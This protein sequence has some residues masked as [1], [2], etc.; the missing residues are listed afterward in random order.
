MDIQHYKN[1]RQLVFSYHGITFLSILALLIG[2][3]RYMIVTN[4]DN[5]YA[6]SLITL[7][8]FIFL[9]LFFHTRIFALK[10]QDRAIRSEETLRY[11]MLTGKRL[12]HRLT[13]RQI[14]ALRFASDEE[15]PGLVQRAA[16]EGLSGDA[17][18]RS[19]QKWRADT[20]RV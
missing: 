14:I 15:F 1:H 3:I 9:S 6:A 5:F 11:F 16:D 4:R 13:L 2:S 20:Y 18:K 10:A 12:D 17:I 8:A 19:I 7:I